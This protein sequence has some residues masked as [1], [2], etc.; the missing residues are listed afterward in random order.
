MKCLFLI[1]PVC[2][3]AIASYISPVQAQDSDEQALLQL[4]RNW[5]TAWQ[6]GD[7]VALNAILDDGYTE[8][9]YSGTRR[10]KLDAILAAPPPSSA[11]QVLEGM[12]TRLNG[13]TGI[14]TGIGRFR[15]SPVSKPVSFR[16]TDVFV[17]R[18]GTWRII[19]SQISPAG[20]E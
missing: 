5:Q 10:H 4:E 15:E 19:T 7:R 20:N 13:D 12:E 1:A 18:E 17:K 6:K 9:T 3:L 2:A 16:F 11:T 8:T 14:V